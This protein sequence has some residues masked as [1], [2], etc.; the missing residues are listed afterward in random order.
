[1]M[2]ETLK[3]NQF[4]TVTADPNTVNI[5]VKKVGGGVFYVDLTAEEAKT[6]AFWLLNPWTSIRK[7]RDQE[8]G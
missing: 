2:E 6:L 3:I 8:E 7:Y 4:I 5:I 1:M